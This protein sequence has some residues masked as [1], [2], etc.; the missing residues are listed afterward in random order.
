[1]VALLCRFERQKSPVTVI[2][3]DKYRFIDSTLIPFQEKYSSDKAMLN[4]LNPT[5]STLDLWVQLKQL[6]KLPNLV[7]QLLAT[8]GEN[9]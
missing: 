2:F 5:V 7:C 4:G 3:D 6:E 1:M 9:A 8:P